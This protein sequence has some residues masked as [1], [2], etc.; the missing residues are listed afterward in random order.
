MCN[1]MDGLLPRNKY[2]KGIKYKEHG[3]T[4]MKFQNFGKYGRFYCS[5]CRRS[6]SLLY[7]TWFAQI[8]TPI[9]KIFS[10]MYS[11]C[12]GYSYKKCQKETLEDENDTP[13]SETTIAA[14]I[15]KFK[16]K[17]RIYMRKN[18]SR[19]TYSSLCPTQ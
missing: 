7:R 8:H 6:Q 11:F 5:K 12:E 4:T 13:F 10:I 3:Q 9:T 2:C 19:V 17:V 15:Y 16:N 18:T 1:R 14:W